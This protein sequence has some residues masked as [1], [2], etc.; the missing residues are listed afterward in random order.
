MMEILTDTSKFELLNDDAIKITLKRENQVKTLLRKLKAEKCINE[1][2]Y[3]ELYPTGTRIGILYGLPKIHKSS[4]PLRPILSSIDHYSYKLAKFFIP[5]LTPISANS[6]VIKDSFSFVQDLLQSDINANNVVMASFDVKSLFTNIP[7]D[8]TIA[9]ITNHIFSSNTS[10]QGLDSSQFTQLL[11]LSVKNCH[12]F[13]N[14][15]VY[16]QIDGVAMGSPLGPLFANIFMAFTENSWLHNCPSTFKPLL[17]QRYVD[18]C[19]LLFRSLDHIPLFLTYLNHQHPN[20]SFTSELEKDNTLPFLDVKITR[21]NGKFSTSVYR[22]PT[23]TGLF[24]N[25]H[26]FIPIQYKR[27]LISSLLHRIFNL[28]SSYEHFHTELEVVRKMFTLNNFPSY[29]FDNHVHRFLNNTFEPKDLIHIAP[30]KIMYFCLPFTG[31][32]CLQI[33]TLITRLCNAAFP[34]INVRFVFRSSRRLSSFFPFKDRV[35][36]LLRS[37]VMS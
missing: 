6:H 18:D 23:F 14:G 16:Q 36:K 28:C 7:V 1:K 24:T 17:Y 25:F 2:T 8:E 3:N 32:H 35:P 11:S 9:I 13:F 15:Q 12:F 4:I 19:F 33:R 34:H 27:S 26:S 20:I 30:K 31:L 37:G 10:F 21:S 22:K 5:L 29:I